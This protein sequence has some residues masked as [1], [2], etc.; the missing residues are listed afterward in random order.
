MSGLLLVD[1]PAG[2]T[3][4]D[5]VDHLRRATGIRRIGHTGTLD[6]NATGLLVLCIDKATR[7]SEHLT[8]LDKVY[9]GTM[10]LGLTTSSYDLDGELVE[11]RP[12]PELTLQ[13][14]QDVC[15]RYIG[16]IEQIPPMVSAV[17]VGGERLYKI[18]RKGETVERKPRAVTVYEFTAISY[19]PPDVIV[20]VACTSGTYVRGLCHDAGQDLGCGAV[21]AALRRTKVGDFSI[22][23][24]RPVDEFKTPDDVA[25]RLLPMDKALTLPEVTVRASAMPAL[26]S[27]NTLGAP[28]LRTACPVSEGWVQIKSERGRLLALG[29]AEATDYGIV[30]Q[31]KRVFGN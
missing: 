21:L 10:R 29:L 30:V 27:G 4:H 17:K 9:E 15:N 19:S 26:L 14:I 6:P 3:S 11:E 13:Q 1:K 2:M 18:A 7:L 16:D 24:A 23:D 20:R 5:V 8:G 12:V 22:E 31:P 28:E 25:A